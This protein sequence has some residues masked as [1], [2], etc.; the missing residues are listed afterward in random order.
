MDKEFALRGP[1]L[2]TKN[3]ILPLTGLRFIAALYVFLFHMQINW[4]FAPRGVVKKVIEQGAVGMSVFFVLSGFLLAYQYSGRYEDK[5][6]YFLKR[7]ARIYP[8]YVVAALST[9]P[10]MWRGQIFT[11][12]ET[13]TLVVTNIF[14]MQAWVPSYFNFWNNGGSWS[15]SVEVFCYAILPFVAPWMSKLS[16]RRLVSF[17]VLLYAWSVIPG[18]LGRVWP[19]LPFSFFYAL[20]A[21]RVSE[22]LLGVCGF[23]AIQRGFR[24]SRPNLAVVVILVVFVLLIKRRAPG[25]QYI[26]Y[27][28]MVMPV[29][30]GLIMSLC[31]S[32]GRISKL[33]SCGV[34]VWLGKISYCFYSFQA[35]VLLLLIKFHE[36]LVAMFSILSMNWV[37]C[38]FAFVILI[39]LSALGYHFIEEPCRRKIQKWAA[40]RGYG[41]PSKKES[42]AV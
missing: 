18:Q 22:F 28:W 8:I 20:P 4:P 35:L 29:V 14:V 16:N 30:V 3:E 19:D 24:F 31:Q 6:G 40:G 27:N 1:G 12:W 15:I 7:L 26:G 36:E 10:W 23:L 41:R 39:L 2:S 32:D 9:I 17:A 5:K 34:F 38:I 21:F 42:Y 37:L 25:I 13:V 33:L 11:A